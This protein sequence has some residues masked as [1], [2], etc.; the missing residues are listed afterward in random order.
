VERASVSL[1]ERPYQASIHEYGIA[2]KTVGDYALAHM[3][4]AIAM[5]FS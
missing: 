1:F 5:P 2:F 4:I 3:D